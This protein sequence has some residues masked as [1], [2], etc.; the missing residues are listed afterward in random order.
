M[1]ALIEISD[2]LVQTFFHLYLLAVL[3]RLLLQLTRAD[4]Y[5]P[6]S[7]F[8][9]KI[10]APPLQP[11]RRIIPSIGGIDMSS[12]VL[13]LLLQIAAITLLLL[14]HGAGIINPLRMLLWAALGCI[15]VIVNI[16]FFAILASIILS[17]VAPGSYN[18]AVL[19]LHQ[20]TEPV[21]APFRKVVPSIGGLDISP[22]LVFLVINIIQIILR[23][24]AASIGLAYGYTHYV[25]GI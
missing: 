18:P 9:V 10:T 4:F 8:I 12:V 1:G 6:I 3:L 15:G 11:L 17:W 7:Q 16:Y 24:V 21:M 19:L 14:L 23:N 20:L 22:I 25:I 13:A 2:L 5:N